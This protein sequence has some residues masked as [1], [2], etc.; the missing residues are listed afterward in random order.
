MGDDFEVRYSPTLMR[1]RRRNE[2]RAGWLSILL[3]I[4]CFALAFV[5]HRNH[6]W[7]DAGRMNQHVYVPPW[8][9]VLAGLG[10]L[11]LGAWILWTNLKQERSKPVA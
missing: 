10:L 1:E 6:T 3:A 5:A 7:V 9:A 2:L 8:L 4:V 11:C